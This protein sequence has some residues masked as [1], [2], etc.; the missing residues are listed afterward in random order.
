MNYYINSNFTINGNYSWNKLNEKGTEDPIIPAYN[1]PEYKYNLGLV[2]RDIHLNKN[3]KLLRNFGFSINY[4]WV[5]GFEYEGSPQFTGFV[6]TY[7]LI[8]LQ[9][10]KKFINLNSTLK[11]GASNL[12]DNMHYEVY[13]G[14]YI[15][16]MIYLSIL[17]ELY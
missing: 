4:K 16:R 12:L 10:S 8:D 5:K 15:G 1:T 11:L 7:D 13:G 6:P 14:P 2:G 9:I 3:K 17:F